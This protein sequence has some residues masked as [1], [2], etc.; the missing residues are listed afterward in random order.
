[1]L[2]CF[3]VPALSETHHA[4]R[5]TVEV[6]TMVHDRKLFDPV[7]H[8]WT[9]DAW[10]A[11]GSANPR[12]FKILKRNTFQ[13]F[14]NQLETVSRHE[15]S[16]FHHKSNQYHGGEAAKLTACSASKTGYLKDL[17]DRFGGVDQV[18]LWAGY[19]NL[20][21]R[22]N[23]VTKCRS[24]FFCTCSRRVSRCIKYVGE[25]K[26]HRETLWDSAQSF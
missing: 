18:L 25:R 4:A 6:Q 9:A 13:H 7:R 10:T 21:V 20:G 11:V 23:E 16:K 14:Q 22:C 2:F 8:T 1:M 3:F 24:L 19:P 5:L 26:S 17:V 15:T 12:C